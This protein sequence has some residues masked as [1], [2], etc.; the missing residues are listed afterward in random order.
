MLAGLIHAVAHNHHP[1]KRRGEARPICPGFA[2]HEERLVERAKRVKQLGKA[3][4]RNSGP[5]FQWDCNH[6]HLVLACRFLSK[7]IMRMRAHTA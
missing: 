6:P 5:C 4:R 1:V 7:Q 2:M 3:C